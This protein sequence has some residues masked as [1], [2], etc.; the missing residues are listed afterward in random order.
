MK[1]I[2]V[3]D[4]VHRRL[5][6]S[7]ATWGITI[8]EALDRLLGEARGTRT[9]ARVKDVGAGERQ[10]QDR[11]G[12]A[13]SRVE[14]RASTRRAVV[15][16]PADSTHPEAEPPDPAPTPPSQQKLSSQQTRQAQRK[17]LPPAN[18]ERRPR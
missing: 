2:R 17:Q 9:Q 12:A 7:A 16:A 13:G 14:G 4:E 1:L 6:V 8:P 18:Y 5:K 10:P 3:S 15:E 11:D